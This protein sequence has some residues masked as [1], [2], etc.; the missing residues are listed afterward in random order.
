MEDLAW[1]W[2]IAMLAV[3]SGVVVAL[4][5]IRQLGLLVGAI[6]AVALVI[7]VVRL[8]V[9]GLGLALVAAPLAP[10]EKELLSIPIDSGQAL[11]GLTVVCFMTR[12]LMRKHLLATLRNLKFDMA[13]LMLL[14]GFI[15]VAVVSFFPAAD[16]NAWV[17]ECLKW[18]EVAGVYLI[19]ANTRNPGARVVIL[20]AI[21]ITG[22][23]Q[24][25]LGLY[26]FAFRGGAP[27]HFAISGR[28]FRAFGTFQQPNP[29]GGF[30]GL[31]WPVA[32]GVAM[33]ILAHDAPR[34]R[35]VSGD[36]TPTPAPWHRWLGW[37]FALTAVVLL[38]ALVASWSRG[39]WLAAGIAVTGMAIVASRKP[40]RALVAIGVVAVILVAFN[41]MD[42]L[43]TSIRD[44]LTGFTDQFVG[45]EIDVRYMDLNGTTFATIERVAHWQA[46]VG[47]ITDHPWLGVG[48]GNYEIAYP[49]YR[50][51]YWV[52]GLGHAHN[53]YLNIWAETGVLGLLS[54][55]LFWIYVIIRT[56]R[57]A[58]GSGRTSGRNTNWLA[59]GILGA[60][61]ALAA[62]NIVDDLYV[63]NMFLFV[64]V[65]LGLL[66][67]G[68]TQKT[69]SR[70]SR[71]NPI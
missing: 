12:E 5:D 33:T 46:A 21:I 54:Y 16:F 44:R 4:L 3:A 7:L 13:T 17:R 48:F 19:V 36:A 8:P 6:G 52:N 56:A 68:F 64:G 49:L 66:E 2:M 38:A 55:L 43:P 67:H 37:C 51:L 60:W 61:L 47:M 26:Q 11:L 34:G 41:L 58:I 14:G 39:A 27:D 57:L 32:A 24:G 40:G 31:L 29:F 63:A 65:L 59:L 9:L 35:Q 10:L 15:A 45:G 42:Y 28:F 62:H 20:G 25:G 70:V 69:S 53:Y 22:L 18:A 71:L 30:M 1:R 50:T 23:I